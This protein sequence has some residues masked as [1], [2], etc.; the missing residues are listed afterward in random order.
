MVPLIISSIN[1]AYAG[2]FSY[3]LKISKLDRKI[4]D[5]A[6]PKF[7]HACAFGFAFGLTSCLLNLINSTAT[8]TKVNGQSLESK[9]PIIYKIN[10][11][12]CTVL[13]AF[14]SV[15]MLKA[16]NYE[17]SFRFAAICALPLMI[18]QA[19]ATVKKL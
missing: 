15:N 7:S 19:N 6:A 16:M 4:F 17:A 18:G 5:F 12:F 11:I 8:S 1:A 9:H 14:I 3:V 13:S 10:L 2:A